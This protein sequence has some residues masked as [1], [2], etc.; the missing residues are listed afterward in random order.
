LCELKTLMSNT[1]C[2]IAIAEHQACV[3]K[4][5]SNNY[6]IY[7]TDCKADIELMSS[8]YPRQNLYCD[9]WYSRAVYAIRHV[10]VRT[11]VC[12]A[13]LSARQATRRCSNNTSP[14]GL[15]PPT[16]VARFL[17]VPCLLGRASICD[18]RLLFHCTDYRDDNRL[19]EMRVV[20]HRKKVVETL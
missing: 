8:V 18:S 13:I 5:Q 14:I 4:P 19:H 17:A 20:R 11:L 16:S 2:T 3:Q 12:T 9:W 10:N 7:T 6:S 15:T 1:M